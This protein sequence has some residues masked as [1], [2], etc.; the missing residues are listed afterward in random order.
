MLAV[1]CWAL[2]NIY[3]FNF[4]EYKL[5]I[6]TY[7]FKKTFIFQIYNMSITKNFRNNDLKCRRY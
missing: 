7:F 3:T 4:A 2:N 5:Y 1:S 6:H